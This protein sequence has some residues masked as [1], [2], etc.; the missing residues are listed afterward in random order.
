[1][2]N[3]HDY[4]LRGDTEADVH[5]GMADAGI[6]LLPSTM[7]S[8]DPIGTICKETGTVDAEGNPVMEPIP[9]WH[10]NLRMVRALSVGEEMALDGVLIPEPQHPVRVWA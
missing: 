8:Y 4:W 1:M 5:A 3:F 9:G 10:A 6:A 2:S 7:S